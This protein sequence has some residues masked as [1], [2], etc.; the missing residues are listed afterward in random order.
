MTTTGRFIAVARAATGTAC[1]P[2]LGPLYRM[3]IPKSNDRW[4]M[5]DASVRQRAMALGYV[6]EGFGSDGVAMCV[7]WP[8][9][10]D[11][12]DGIDAF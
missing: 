10:L 7:Y 2:G 8:V 6:P 9:A 12:D 5:A 11:A 3:W 4:F 1:T